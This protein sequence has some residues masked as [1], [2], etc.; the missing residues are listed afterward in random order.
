LIDLRYTINIFSLDGVKTMGFPYHLRGEPEK[1]GEQAV[2]CPECKNDIVVFNIEVNKNDE[3][4][5]KCPYCDHQFESG[6]SHP[7]HR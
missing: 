2:T 1:K 7:N 6:E 3:V 4:E 5:K